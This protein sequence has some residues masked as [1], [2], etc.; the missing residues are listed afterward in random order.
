[1]SGTFQLAPDTIKTEGGERTQFYHRQ[2]TLTPLPGTPANRRPLRILLDCE[3]ML[4]DEDEVA[5]AMRLLARVPAA[6]PRAFDLV[7]ADAIYGTAP[8][9]NFLLSH[10][11]DALV[12][13]KDERRSLYHD[14]AGLFANI[15]PHH[16]VRH[17]VT[18]SGGTSPAWFRGRK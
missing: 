1:M 9:L 12:V 4:P 18:A 5:T 6:Y 8:F 17:G 3:P 7:L 2:V 10:G 15:E 13:L 16:G 11:K 14:V